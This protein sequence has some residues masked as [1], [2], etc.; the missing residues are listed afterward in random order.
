MSASGTSS[1]T[2]SFLS[3]SNSGEFMCVRTSVLNSPVLDA[4]ALSVDHIL[5]I[6]S[7]GSSDS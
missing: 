7:E 5:L 2:R 4:S 6:P 3:S 1:R